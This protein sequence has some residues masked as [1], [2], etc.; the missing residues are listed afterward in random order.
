M[1]LNIKRTDLA[2][3]CSNN[4]KIHL[5]YEDDKNIEVLTVQDKNQVRIIKFNLLNDNVKVVLKKELRFFLD[6]IKIKNHCLVV[7][8]GNEN[9]TADSVG[10]LVLKNITINSFLNEENIK[11]NGIKV[12]ALEPGVLGQTGIDTT[13][14]IASVVQEVKCDFLIVIDSYVSNRPESLEKTIQISNS[15]I[16][17]G[18]GIMAVNSTITKKNIGIPIIVI[19]VPTALEMTI[20]NKNYILASNIIDKYVLEVAKIISEAI[21]EVLYFS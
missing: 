4:K 3:E 5:Y 14:I 1:Y 16:T 6:R 11:I 21:N 13:R 17:P 15:G 2:N 12:S 8:L 10:P 19:G 9:Y 18:S 20:K 7:G